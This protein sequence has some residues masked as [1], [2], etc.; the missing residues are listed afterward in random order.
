VPIAAPCA[1]L[2]YDPSVAGPLQTLTTPPYDQISA[3]DQERF[4]RDSPFNAVRLELGGSPSPEGG[5]D[6]Y[7]EAAALLSQWRQG[8]VLQEVP[9]AAVYPYEMRFQGLGAH[10]RVRGVI[11]E[12]ELEPW[13]GSVIP[14]EG[15]LPGPLRDRLE[16]LRAVRANL[17]PVYGVY[18][19]RSAALATLLDDVSRRPPDR[20][21]TDEAGTR[22]SLWIAP[23]GN[24]LVPEVLRSRT[25]M[26]ADGHHRYEVALAY[27][28]EMRAL[29]GPGPWD[30]LMMLVVDASS[31]PPLVLP[32]HRALTRPAPIPPDARRV[33]DLQELLAGLSDDE[34]TVGTVRMEGSEAIHS[35]GTVSGHPPTVGALQE[36]L[37]EGVDPADVQY[38]ADA[39]LAETMVR[40]GDAH[41][42]YLLPATTVER[43]R[44]VVD[45]G[46]RLPEKST[47]FWPKP[48]T[49]MVFRL[50]FT[51]VASPASSPPSPR[52]R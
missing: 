32:F 8:G 37:L 38:V 13:G 7:A 21:V 30:R 17:S 5:P 42:A 40:R 39:A 6:R 31:E 33:R 1:G 48:R 11:V 43:I 44:A 52:P 23:E 41:T 20:E 16:L 29:H 35:L 9:G 34:L 4:R 22:H 24:D 45:S 28:E 27:R 47:Y 12:V 51:P 50:A 15:T 49:G 19:D 36:Q 14:H 18:Q 10:R 26:I 3:S 46:R 25:V 2:E